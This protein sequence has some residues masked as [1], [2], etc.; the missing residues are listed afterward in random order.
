[1]DLRPHPAAGSP[2]TPSEPVGL[3]LADPADDAALGG[4]HPR[5]GGRG[6]AGAVRP[7]RPPGSDVRGNVAGATACRPAPRGVLGPWAGGAASSSSSASFFSNDRADADRS[8]GRRSRPATGNSFHDVDPLASARS[9]SVTRFVRSVSRTSADRRGDR[10]GLIPGQAVVA[11]RRRT[12][13]CV[14][15]EGQSWATFARSSRPASIGRPRMA[16]SATVAPSSRRGKQLVGRRPAR[17]SR[18]SVSGQG[19]HRGTRTGPAGRDRGR[20]TAGRTRRAGPRTRTA[21]APPRGPSGPNANG[22]GLGANLA[23][24]RCG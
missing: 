23:A 9:V 6:A 16:A 18:A 22:A 5:R 4:D 11:R 7:E 1:M 8:S 14:S 3:R 24:A 15:S 20:R 17:S 19:V 10:L 13:A 21:S 12:R 2:C